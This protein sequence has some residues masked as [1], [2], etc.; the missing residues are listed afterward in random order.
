MLT[1]LIFIVF[2]ALWIALLWFGITPDF[3]KWSNLGLLAMHVLPPAIAS[4][5]WWTGGILIKRHKE[6]QAEEHKK[7][8]EAEQQ[9]TLEEARTRHAQELQQRRFACD[10]KLV[11]I[12][13]LAIHEQCDFPEKG[14][15]WI[16]T[17]PAKEKALEL[18]QTNI[19]NAFEPALK[20]ALCQVYQCFSAAA[21]FPIYIV[22]PCNVAAIDV[23]RCLR[24]I[25]AQLV[26]ELGLPVKLKDGM[27]SILHL[28]SGDSAANRVIGLF[29]TTPDLPGA[30][31]LAFDSSLSQVQETNPSDRAQTPSDTPVG[32]TGHGVFALLVTHP[33]LPA[34]V[35]SVADYIN[36]DKPESMIPFWEKAAQPQGNLTLLT[37]A[38]PALRAALVHQP[39]VARIHRAAFAQTGERPDHVLELENALI[40]L[41]KQ[42]QIQA[43]LM[44][45]PF[46]N[47][48]N[49][50]QHASKSASPQATPRC[51]WL[52]HNAGDLQLAGSRTAAI[53]N[54]LMHFQIELPP[55]AKGTNVVRQLGDLGRATSIGMLAIALVQ[56]RATAA[57]VLCTE[58]AEPDRVAVTFAMPAPSV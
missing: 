8:A 1:L 38:P 41:L 56:A 4:M 3:S 58:F 18:E 30:V 12:I 13:D 52:V 11:S 25:H 5:A 16:Q 31:V 29:D 42:A 14:S 6:R 7:K 17:V 45:L 57:P 35:E 32:K 43:G 44:E 28:P 22:P 20:Q 46:V 21:A 34:M 2:V 53:A 37:L 47:D 54:A 51:E 49:A 9:A 27:P 15:V 23:H 39:P 33:E 55:N 26:A 48:S 50:A 40:P 36:E 24:D 19:L 10:C